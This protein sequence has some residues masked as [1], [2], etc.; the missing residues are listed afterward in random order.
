MICA[1]VPGH[2]EL[3]V[4]WTLNI[5]MQCKTSHISK[6]LWETHSCQH[7]WRQKW[8]QADSSGRSLILAGTCSSIKSQ[9]KRKKNANL[10][11]FMSPGNASMEKRLNLK[12]INW[13]Y[14]ES[15]KNI[16]PW[17]N[18]WKK[19]S[20]MLILFHFSK[21][22]HKS[23]A[24]FWLLCRYRAVN[25]ANLAICSTNKVAYSDSI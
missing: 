13:A 5:T 8:H 11:T 6:L 20:Q 16:E 19:I 22:E 7:W 21:R 9:Q 1:I 2:T 10:P 18:W 12:N 24:R 4:Q 17:P 23:F 25:T 14:T 3:K 15:K